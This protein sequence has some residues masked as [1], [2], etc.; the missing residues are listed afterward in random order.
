MDRTTH[1]LD[2]TVGFCQLFRI[3]I[4]SL[5]PGMLYVDAQS[6]GL[7]WY[8]GR[9]VTNYRFFKKQALCERRVCI[10]LDLREGLIV[11]NKCILLR[12]RFSGEVL[13]LPHLTR[14]GCY[15]VY[16]VPLWV[17]FV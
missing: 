17:D 12:M 16:S 10:I 1:V 2:S 5:S 9:F 7:H 11:R 6:G 13:L 8:F 4:I 15:F 3:I 14:L